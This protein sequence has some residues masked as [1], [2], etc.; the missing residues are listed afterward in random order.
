MGLVATISLGDA[1]IAAVASVLGFYELW[2]FVRRRGEREHLWVALISFCAAIYST[3]MLI[4]Y[5]AGREHIVFLIKLELVP[6]V[7]L[8]VLLLLLAGEIVGRRPPG[9]LVGIV[10][11]PSLVAL[12]LLPTS[13][14]I[15][16][17]IQEHTLLLLHR[18]FPRYAPTPAVIAL[19][20]WG[21]VAALVVATWLFK[22][23]PRGDRQA[24]NFAIAGFAWLAFAGTDGI[25][26][27]LAAPVPMNLFE[28]GYVVAAAMLV[29]SHV[30]RYM[31]ML[32]ASERGF[33]AV[34]DRAPDAV[35]AVQGDSVVYANP[36]L[37]NLL[38]RDLVGGQI[39]DL[40]HPDDLEL[41]RQLRADPTGRSP[42][43][44]RMSRADGVQVHLEVVAVELEGE[45]SDLLMARDVTQ[46]RRLVAQVM[47]MDRLISVGTL[48]AA[49]G[50]E[51]NNPLAY[52]TLNLE[53]LQREVGDPRLAELARVALEGA[54]RIKDTVS[55]L[56]FFSR[57]H[58]SEGTI[59]LDEV[60]RSAV[61]IAGNEIR[62]RALLDLNL[63][64]KIPLWGN[65]TRLAQ[66]F[67]NLLTNAAE[68]I[69]EGNQSENCIYVSCRRVGDRALF[70]V[71]DTGAGIA[72]E[73]MAQIFDAFYTSGPESG[74]SLGLG[75][76]R[77][78]IR[79]MGG[80]LTVSSTLREGTTLKGEL[81][82]VEPEAREQPAAD[83]ER[84]P[85]RRRPR[86]LVVD[87]E[88]MVLHSI[89]RRLRADA[90]VEGVG[91]MAESL[92]A[93]DEKPFDLILTDMM[94]PNGSGIDLYQ[95]LLERE[96][97][98]AARMVFMS[99]GVFTEEARAFKER[100]SNPFVDKPLDMEVVRRLVR[101]AVGED[102]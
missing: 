52:V 46:R 101:S 42:T 23:R 90:E 33:R 17:R 6:I 15:S 84:P 13:I 16:D 79:S 95:E 88:P 81:P 59:W 91:S 83:T 71:N 94:M 67:V 37:A 41:L 11:V 80:E 60:I 32:A 50:H 40:V 86:I 36:A 55:V 8:L 53:E 54:A 100:T 58:T 74:L 35:A 73:R 56:H 20:A 9:W 21:V 78:T 62:H 28:Y 1:A 27:A 22:N 51:I 76:S 69:P 97:K 3:L 44:L 4:H 7:A 98:L 82:V 14:V 24:R 70:E 19:M 89:C 57:P 65:E 85:P 63:E 49:V 26:G 93:L 39:A 31:E 64:P 87:D 96:P 102:D 61:A 29:L 5:N 25:L 45:G 92:E 38:D 72:P 68:A 30:Q 77:E 34:I 66:V 43:P 99:G 48:A 2:L 12:A 18:P 47:E 10:V 75:I